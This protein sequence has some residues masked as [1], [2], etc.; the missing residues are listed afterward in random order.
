MSLPHGL[1]F[2]GLSV[3]PTLTLLLVWR[4]RQEGFSLSELLAYRRNKLG[5]DLGLGV[6][7]S[8]GIALFAAIT[9]IVLSEI[10]PE[11]ADSLLKHANDSLAMHTPVWFIAWSALVTPLGAAIVEE[12]TYRGY[13]LPRLMSARLTPALA[14]WLTSV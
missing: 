2:G 13:A 8:I 9:A 5:V 3:Y 1:P 11:V 14:I 6:A 12:L 10:S 4:S 7:T